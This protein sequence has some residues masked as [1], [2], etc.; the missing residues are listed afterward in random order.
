VHQVIISKECLSLF[1]VKYTMIPVLAM[2]VIAASTSAV[3][4]DTLK[5][6]LNSYSQQLDTVKGQASEQAKNEDTAI[7]QA[8]SLQASAD[9]LKIGLKNDTVVILEHKKTMSDIKDKEK[10]LT[11][12]RQ[13]EI[14]SLGEYLNAEYLKSSSPAMYN[15]NFLLGSNSLSDLMTRASYLENI[16]GAYNKLG[17]Q[18]KADTEALAENK[19]VEEVTLDK[20]DQA[21]QSKLLVQNNLN[22]AI[23][24][25]KQVVASLN[26]KSRKILASKNSLQKDVDHVQSLIDTQEM[27]AKYAQQDKAKNLPATVSRSGG[28]TAPV[29]FNGSASEIIN[30]AANFLGTPYVWGGSSPNPGFDCS[31]LVQYSFAHFGINL[32]RVTWDQFNQ[33]SPVAS[34]ADLKAGDLVFFSTY[35]PGPSHVGIY[36]GGGMMIDDENRGVV[37]SN[38]NNSYYVNKFVGGRR[39]IQ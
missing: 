33:G 39:V 13:Q 32:P 21:I 4:A 5:D 18:I 27:E 3:Y 9:L 28:F 26:E 16:V 30:F 8:Q 20:L 6:N 10:A 19:K 2:C 34:K 1:N 17:V 36:M 37:Y 35:A 11:E 12:K 31:S 23:D 24:K 22:A 38:I 14:A 7:Q 15:I 25:Q 29:K